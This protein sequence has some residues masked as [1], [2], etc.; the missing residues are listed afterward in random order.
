MILLYNC[1]K[2]GNPNQNQKSGKG[3]EVQVASD[4]Q[5][6]TQRASLAATT[7]PK[8]CKQLAKWK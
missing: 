6:Q 7:Q 2:G 8:H 4:A 3:A 1:S 5:A